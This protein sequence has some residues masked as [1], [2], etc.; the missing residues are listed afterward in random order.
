MISDRAFAD[1]AKGAADR[2]KATQAIA[3]YVSLHP[4]NLAEKTEVM[5]E[6]FRQFTKKKI[7]GKAK[8]MVVTRW[9]TCCQQG[10]LA[11]DFLR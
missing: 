7:G 5:V 10:R 3:R 1:A 2:K 8:A 4:H 11:L 6:H 9:R